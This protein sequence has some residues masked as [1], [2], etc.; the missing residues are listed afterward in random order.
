MFSVN[1]C[2]IFLIQQSKQ[3]HLR[4]SCVL[5]AEQINLHSLTVYFT[6]PGMRGSTPLDVAA[7]SCID[8]NELALA[9]QEQ[10]L[11]MV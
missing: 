8:N 4:V 3:P 2:E 1:C 5:G 7:A 11:D 6:H 9:L 10:D